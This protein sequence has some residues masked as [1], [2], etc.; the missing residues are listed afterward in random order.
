MPVVA[1]ATAGIARPTGQARTGH[2]PHMKALVVTAGIA[3]GAAIV[4]TSLT[5]ALQRSLIY[6]P[7]PADPGPASEQFA[8]GTDVALHTL[9]G[10]TLAAWQID[11]TRHSAAA[12]PVDSAPPGMA[13]LYLPGNAGNRLGRVEVAQTIADRGFT[14]LLVDYRGYA[15]NPGSPSEDGLILDARAAAS[16]LR[17]LG[18]PAD[19]TI[20]VGESIG[21]G[22]AT[23]L[24][25]T[26]PPAGLLLRSP[27]TSLTDVARHNFHLPV[28]WVLRDRFDT[29]ARITRVR[30]P[31]SVLAGEAD[32]LV[33]ASQSR[34]VAARASDLH[35]LLIVPGAGHN[36]ALWFGPFLAQHVA[37]LAA[38]ASR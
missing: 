37:S 22:V 21:T 13:V 4:L 35:E 8:T 6:F 7:D 32:D 20:Y 23:A 16:F 24:A 11:P 33:P 3:V 34:E 28:G 31:V 15:G 38:A 2:T 29:A 14:V 17:D 36:D 10:L 25:T 18:F 9:D 1:H 26:D 30:S 12:P 27:F 5:W 19:R